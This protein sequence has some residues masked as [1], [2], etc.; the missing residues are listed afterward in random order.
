MTKEEKLQEI[1][2]KIKDLQKEESLLVKEIIKD[3]ESFEEKFKIWIEHDNGKILSDLFALRSKSPYI[4][5]YLD[6]FDHYHRCETILFF[7]DNEDD[8]LWMID[9]FKNDNGEEVDFYTEE[10][11]VEIK[12][13]AE[14]MMKHNIKG[15]IYDW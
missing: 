11:K 10:R 12:K 15:V 1:R 3:K 2:N 5:N 9:N 6:K 14:E 7:E 8:L 4:R 13:L